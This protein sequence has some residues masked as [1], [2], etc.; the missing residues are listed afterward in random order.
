MNTFEISQLK[1][2]ALVLTTVAQAIKD[3][4]AKIE[5]LEMVKVIV[6][7][8]HELEKHQTEEEK[9]NGQPN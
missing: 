4:Q 2:S 1:R 8:V 9:K 5:T 6:K 7:A 3:P